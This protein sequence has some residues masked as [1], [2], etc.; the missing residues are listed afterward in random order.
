MA[1]VT[2]DGVARDRLRSGTRDRRRGAT[3]DYLNTHETL[4]L[5]G[6]CGSTAQTTKYGQILLEKSKSRWSLA[7]WLPLNVRTNTEQATYMTDND[8]IDQ[9]LFELGIHSCRSEEEKLTQDTI[10][11]NTIQI[12][13]VRYEK[14]W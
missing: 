12:N 14:K 3:R 13:T 10:Q 7:V 2:D 5:N 4:Q 11:I 1:H 8:S 9:M 6:R